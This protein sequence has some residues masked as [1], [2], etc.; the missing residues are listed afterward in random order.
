[1]HSTTWSDAVAL[2]ESGDEHLD[3]N[4]KVKTSPKGATGV[5]QLMP[6]TAK[7]LGVD[8]TD[9]AQ[10]REGGKRYLGAMFDKYG[11]WDD[12]L[13][14]YNWGPGNV[15]KWIA[16]GRNEDQMPAETKNYISDTIRRAGMS[17]V[18]PTAVVKE[19]R[20]LTSRGLSGI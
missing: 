19:K 11:N 15:D 18:A 8:P 4:G 5:M 17:E 7:G 12:A 3:K 2:T 13:A 20:R 6:E 9:E 16:R 1:M 10:N 14:A